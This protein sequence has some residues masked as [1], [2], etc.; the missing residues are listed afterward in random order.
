M[1]TNL[2]P[3]HEQFV[4]LLIAGKSYKD[5]ANELEVNRATLTVW[6]QLETVEARYNQLV[7]EVKNDL[8]SGLIGL[9]S[10]A[11]ETVKKCLTSEN[12]HTRLKAA[13]WLIEKAENLKPG[14]TDPKE[15][16][17]QAATKPAYDFGD[18]ENLDT[19]QYNKRVAELGLAS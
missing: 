7:T 18:F 11:V 14:L 15:I 10:E 12:D 6:R 1:E 16:I 13:L 8:E 3:K 4:A 2:Q 17:R 5:I 9:Y 19:E